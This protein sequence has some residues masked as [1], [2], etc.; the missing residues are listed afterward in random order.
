MNF[1]RVKASSGSIRSG[2]MRSINSSLE[3]LDIAARQVRKIA[4][5]SLSSQ[6]WIT[7]FMLPND[8]KADQIL[9]Y[10]R[11]RADCVAEASTAMRYS[12]HEVLDSRSRVVPRE[13]GV[14]R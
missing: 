14:V 1:A 7:P 2:R 8:D 10:G 12:L 5:A 4:I 11:I 6:S 9:R 13:R 3:A